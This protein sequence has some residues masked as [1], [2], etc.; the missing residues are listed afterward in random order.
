M[1][2]EILGLKGPQDLREGMGCLA[3]EAIEGRTERRASRES[4]AG[5][6]R[7]DRKGPRGSLVQWESRVSVSLSVQDVMTR[8]P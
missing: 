6:A 8:V 4:L 7:L 3:P 5:R 1:P 2:R